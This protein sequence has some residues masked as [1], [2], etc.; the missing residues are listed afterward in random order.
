MH[1]LVALATVASS[2][3]LNCTATK[4]VST[5]GTPKSETISK[6]EVAFTFRVNLTT[7]LWCWNRCTATSRI[8]AVDDSSITFHRQ[9]DDTG[10][11]VTTVNR[12]T[13]ALFERER[14]FLRPG[15]FITLTQGTCEPS[16][17]TGFPAK[18]F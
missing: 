17:F 9:E 1:A 5:L 14:I 16:D 10:D 15:M 13:G 4:S 11:E 8:A 2:F 18:K 7:G 12:R 3:N 6:D